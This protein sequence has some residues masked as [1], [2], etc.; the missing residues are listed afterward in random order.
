MLIPYVRIIR[1]LPCRDCSTDQ[2]LVWQSDCGCWTFKC[3][4]CGE[5]AGATC[6]EAEEHIEEFNHAG[7]ASTGEFAWC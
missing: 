4:L 1:M 7:L 6:C 3:L 5:Y 2:G